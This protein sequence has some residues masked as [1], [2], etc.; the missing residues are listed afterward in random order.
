MKLRMVTRAAYGL[1]IA[2]LLLLGVTGAWAREWDP[3]YERQVGQQAL[4]QVLKQYELW[5]NPQ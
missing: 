5:D 2:L 4:E 1:T 3:D